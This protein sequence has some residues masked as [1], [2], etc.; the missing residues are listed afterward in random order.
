MNSRD[1]E[2]AGL[3]LPVVVDDWNMQMSLGPLECIRIRSLSCEKQRVEIAQIVLLDQFSFGIFFLDRAKSGR[4]REKALHLVVRDDA[5]ERT[6]LFQANIILI[7][8]DNQKMIAILE[9]TSG[10]PT[11][12][13]SYRI[14]VA[15][16]R[17]GP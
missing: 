13:P 3:S 17:S 6:R 11:G 5:E 8:G 12:L 4:G 9:R 15:P 14:D 16:C 1:E 2:S 10:V 7:I